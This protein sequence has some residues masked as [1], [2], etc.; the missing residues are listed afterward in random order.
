MTYETVDREAVFDHLQDVF[1]RA[2]PTVERAIVFGSVARGDHDETSDV[3]VIVV[4]P[5][6]ED[7]QGA[8]RGKPF[9][10]EWDYGTFGAVD[11]IAYTP[12]EYRSYRT[13]SDSLPRTAEAD[14]VRIA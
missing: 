1:E 14:G 10:D 5:D 9:R 13:R 8:K 2:E 3:D 12:D 6:F 7:V 4:S 11:F